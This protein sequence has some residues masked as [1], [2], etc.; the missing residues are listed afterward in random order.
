MPDEKGRLFASDVAGELDINASD[1]RARVS[2]GYAPAPDD[3]VQDGRMMRP[4]W[5]RETIIKHIA[6]AGR[7][8]PGPRGVA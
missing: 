6:R 5:T 1:W 4:V 2:R 8:G 7:R 3:V